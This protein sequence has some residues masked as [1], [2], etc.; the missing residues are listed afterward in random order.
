MKLK[1]YTTLLENKISQ[2]AKIWVIFI[3]ETIKSCLSNSKL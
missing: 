1:S 2:E 3:I